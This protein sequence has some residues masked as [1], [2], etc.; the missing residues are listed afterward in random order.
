VGTADSFELDIKKQDD[1]RHRWTLSRPDGRVI[2][3][4]VELYTASCLAAATTG[5]DPTSRI[6]VSVDGVP[7]GNFMAMRMQL[8]SSRVALEIGQALLTRRT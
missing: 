3:E 7:A 1:L 4:G 2:D 8:E 5:V 6:V